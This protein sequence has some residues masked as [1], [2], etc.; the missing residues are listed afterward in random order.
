MAGTKG[1]FDE[2]EAAED[3]SLSVNEAFAKRLEVSCS[4]KLPFVDD[5]VILYVKIVANLDLFAYKGGSHWSVVLK[6]CWLASLLNLILK[7]QWSLMCWEE[8][9]TVNDLSRLPLLI[10]HCLI[11]FSPFRR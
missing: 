3:L 6:G 1:L 8:Q 7:I 9:V 4:K 10:L 11:Y 2:D 5:F